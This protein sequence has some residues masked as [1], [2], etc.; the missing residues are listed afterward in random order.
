MKI[1]KKI[2]NKSYS[3]LKS[4]L[5]KNKFQK[6]LVDKVPL[7]FHDVTKF[8]YQKKL[9]SDDKSLGQLVESFRKKIVSDHQGKKIETFGSPHSK[10]ELFDEKG[11]IK[12]GDYGP[13]PAEGVARTGTAIFGGLQLKKIVESIG[14]GRVIEL[15]T[16]TGLS[17]CYFLS[18]NMPVELVTIEGSKKLCEIAEKNLINISNNFQVLNQM[19]DDALSDLINKKEEFDIGFV[20][21]QHEKKA[22]LFYAQELK[23]IVKPGGI[24]IFDDI[25][26][27]EDMNNGWNDLI[28]DKDFSATIDLGNRGICILDKEEETKKHFCLG[29]YI[30]NP[31]VYRSGW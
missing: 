1:V 27:S 22:T 11:K 6:A 15:G 8:S 10:S 5:N 12:P 21:G 14:G 19:F 30:G 7:A 13:R 20:D 17:G 28:K 18:S 31:L 25:Y 29:D 2:I 9:S 23:K 26:W 3:H 16:N 4:I 24:I